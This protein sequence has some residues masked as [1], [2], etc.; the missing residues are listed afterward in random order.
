MIKV[1]NN[2]IDYFPFP[3]LWFSK[4]R[5][6]LDEYM[7]KVV[8]MLTSCVLNMPSKY[9]ASYVTAKYALLGLMRS[10]SVEY[11]DK[12]IRNAGSFY[13]TY[14]ECESH[15]HGR[16]LCQRKVSVSGMWRIMRRKFIKQL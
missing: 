13:E 8:F 10:L 9:Q 1:G 5:K 12:G 4:L 14:R 6:G 11:A 7:G 16:C 2:C 3:S 15:A